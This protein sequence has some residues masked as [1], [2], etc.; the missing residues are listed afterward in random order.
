MQGGI[1]A[2]TRRLLRVLLLRFGSVSASATAA[3]GQRLIR[4]SDSASLQAVAVF[5]ST[6]N[7]G[8]LSKD[9][10]FVRVVPA[11][12]CAPSREGL[13]R[14]PYGAREAGLS[15]AGRHFDRVFA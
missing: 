4:R 12:V 1:A 9:P 5:P 7:P 6:P 15:E 8:F 2:A 14:V 3:E 11:T 10:Q 13:W